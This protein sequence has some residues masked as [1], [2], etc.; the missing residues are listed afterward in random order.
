MSRYCRHK[1]I[2]IAAAIA[3][4]VM[5]TAHAD[6]CATKAGYQRLKQKMT[7][8]QANEAVG[9]EGEVISENETV[10]FDV[11]THVWRAPDHVGMI[12]VYFNHGK[13][14]GKGQFR[15]KE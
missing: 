1:C 9:C 4:A 8:E 6:D 11:V 3:L 10:G 14:T 5:R 2:I 13:L 12:S 15:L 7:M